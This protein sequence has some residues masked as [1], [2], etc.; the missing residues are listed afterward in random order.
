MLKRAVDACESESDEATT[1]EERPNPDAAPPVKRRKSS[2][3]K[4]PNL[5]ETVMKYQD[6]L[7]EF[8]QEKEE[9]AVMR[10]DESLEQHRRLVDLKQQMVEVCC[11]LSSYFT[12]LFIRKI[13]REEMEVRKK[14]LEQNAMKDNLLAKLLEK[15]LAEKK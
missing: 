7:F 4:D 6:K 10:H 2:S 13:K 15:V 14:E 3:N 12:I 8:E 5:S 11:H 9:A 1:S